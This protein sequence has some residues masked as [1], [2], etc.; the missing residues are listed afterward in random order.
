MRNAN[1]AARS[2]Q[3]WLRRVA[4]AAVIAGVGG[5]SWEAGRLAVST[6]AAEIT[7]A[8]RHLIERL[9]A[10]RQCPSGAAKQGSRS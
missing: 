2:G 5:I 9:W 10:G 6:N 3:T 1:T 7:S 8:S 4:W